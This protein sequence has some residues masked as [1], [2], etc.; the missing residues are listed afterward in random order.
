MRQK[1]KG[2]KSKLDEGKT[3]Y[4]S[5]E[6]MFRSWMGS[7]YKVMSKQQRLQLIKMFEEL[8][9]R[10]VLVLLIKQSGKWKMIIQEVM[11]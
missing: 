11:V 7:Y 2:L 5:I 1:M 10:K 9:D 3:T 4:E 6:E 8:F